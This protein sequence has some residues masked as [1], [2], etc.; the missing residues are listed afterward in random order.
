VR[1]RNSLKDTHNAVYIFLAVALGLAAGDQVL[2][3]ALVLS[4]AFCTTMLL[5]YWT[6]FDL[7]RLEHEHRSHHG[8]RGDHHDE[9]GDPK[10]TYDGSA[11]EAEH[12]SNVELVAVHAARS[13]AA[14]RIVEAL[15]SG[16]Y[17]DLKRMW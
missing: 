7:S 2:G 5:L 4:A 10:T 8:A 9:S 3:I 17:S 1:F 11:P 16:P 15:L 6:G 13:D 14:R 12:L